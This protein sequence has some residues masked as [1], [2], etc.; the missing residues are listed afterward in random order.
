MAGERPKGTLI[1]TK[2]DQHVLNE[3]A[4]HYTAAEHVPDFRSA[5][6]EE[7]AAAEEE[8]WGGG[9]GGVGGAGG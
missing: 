2:P 5:L 9:M 1:I 3:H 8:E 4:R 6:M 7:E